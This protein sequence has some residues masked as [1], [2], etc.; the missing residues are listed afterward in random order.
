MDQEF[1]RA[2]FDLLSLSGKCQSPTKGVGFKVYN[3]WF[4]HQIFSM[5][6]YQSSLASQRG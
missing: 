6:T 1:R 4:T 2:T 3:T 5:K